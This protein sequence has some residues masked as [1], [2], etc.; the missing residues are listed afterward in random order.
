M[1]NHEA[2]AQRKAELWL[3]QCYDT[4]EDNEGPEGSELFC[5]CTTCIV[6]EVLTV[7]TPHLYAAL[8]DVLTEEGVDVPPRVVRMFTT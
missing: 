6:R 4:Q 2:N 8:I 7:A 5:G 1:G 3:E